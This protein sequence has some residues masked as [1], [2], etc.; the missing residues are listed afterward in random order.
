MTQ[1]RV[2]VSE[3][4]ALIN[5]A[6]EAAGWEAIADLPKGRHGADRNPLCRALDCSI[7]DGE[8]LMNK[9]YVVNFASTWKVPV[10]YQAG[11]E[12]FSSPIPD[13]LDAFIRQFDDGLFPEYLDPLDVDWE[14]N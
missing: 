13:V 1:N 8:A 11:S 2:D 7:G 3:V 12:I 9:P 6:R 4:L 5:A 10:E 14:Q